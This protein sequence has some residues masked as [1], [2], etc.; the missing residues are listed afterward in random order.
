MGNESDARLEAS[1]ATSCVTV[2]H[3]GGHRPVALEH[4]NAPAFVEGYDWLAS[5]PVRL[6]RRT[7]ACPSAAGARSSRTGSWGTHTLSTQA[8]L[9]PARCPPPRPS[10][11]DSV[12]MAEHCHRACFSIGPTQYAP[13]GVRADRSWLLP[14]RTLDEGR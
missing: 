13:L 2:L 14:H 7:N 9:Q 1:T 3:H 4:P 8:R 5:I 6:P 11:F 12:G 10:W